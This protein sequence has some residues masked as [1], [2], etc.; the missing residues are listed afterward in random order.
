[1]SWYEIGNS[2]EGFVAAFEKSMNSSMGLDFIISKYDQNCNL[3]YSNSK[4]TVNVPAGDTLCLGDSVLLYYN[5]QNFTPTGYQ[6]MENSTIKVIA[7]MLRVLE[8]ILQY[9]MIL[10]A[11]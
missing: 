10:T 4:P 7:F 1:M 2:Q 11:I 9:V 5:K 3:N 6:M 8:I